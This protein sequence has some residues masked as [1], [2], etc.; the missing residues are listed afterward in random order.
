STSLPPIPCESHEPPQ[1]CSSASGGQRLKEQGGRQ[2]RSLFS[3]AGHQD[4]FVGSKL[5][6]VHDDDNISQDIPAPKAVE[7]EEDVARVAGELDAAVCRRGH[8]ESVRQKRQRKMRMENNQASTLNLGKRWLLLWNMLR[9][10]IAP[11]RGSTS[12]LVPRQTVMHH[13]E[14][15]PG[16]LEGNGSAPVV[17]GTALPC[18]HLPEKTHSWKGARAVSAF[19][20][21]L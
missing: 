3:P 4:C 11:G 9:W 14:L 1:D 21:A 6:P 12:S 16:C 17:Q 19:P 8:L 20:A 10:P 7:I 2:G 15:L 13:T 5:L 18:R